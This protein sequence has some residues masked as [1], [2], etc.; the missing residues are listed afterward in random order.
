[1]T[2][3]P[4]Q[5]RHTYR[6]SF[7]RKLMLLVAAAVLLPVLAT[8]VVLGIQLNQQAR[9]L[10]ATGLQGGLEPFAMLVQGQER[11]RVEGVRRTAVDNTLQVTLELGIG[12]QLAAYIETQR[13]VLGLAFLGAYTR[14]GRSAGVARTGTP[15]AMPW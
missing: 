1:M 8:C 2:E 10:F 4:K 7:K 6:R 14:D 9:V 15:D 5:L 13:Q 3:A 11:N 12:G